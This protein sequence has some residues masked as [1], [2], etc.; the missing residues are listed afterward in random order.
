MP[1]DAANAAKEM[2]LPGII[3]INDQ[4]FIK[5]D[6]TTINLPCSVQLLQEAVANLVVYYY[7]LGLNYPEQLK[8]VFFFLKPFSK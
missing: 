7:V 6:N 3:I 8:F 2:E 4:F 5:V 1:A